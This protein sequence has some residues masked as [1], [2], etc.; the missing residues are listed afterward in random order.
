MRRVA[1]N[2][3]YSFDRAL[4]IL[5]GVLLSTHVPLGFFSRTI[6]TPCILDLPTALFMPFYICLV[7]S[8]CMI[9]RV[10]FHVADLIVVFLF[11][12]EPVVWIF[13]LC[14]LLRPMLWM[15]LVPTAN[16]YVTL[17]LLVCILCIHGSS[18]LI[19]CLLRS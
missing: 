10:C 8:T 2:P 14:S 17:L 4:N 6:V 18:V 16:S 15:L 12:R 9:V 1:A 7:P 3:W 11:F 13:L 19:G 5:S